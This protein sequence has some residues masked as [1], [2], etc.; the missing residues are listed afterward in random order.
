[1]TQKVD[2]DVEIIRF[3]LTQ[4]L[5]WWQGHLLLFPGQPK[6][7]KRLNCL[8]FREYFCWYSFKFVPKMFK[9]RGGGVNTSTAF[10]TILRKQQQILAWWGFHI[11]YLCI[12]LCAEQSQKSPEVFL[13]LRVLL[14][15]S[16]INENPST[17]K[18]SRAIKY[19]SP[20]TFLVLRRRQKVF[21]IVGA[22]YW[23][24]GPDK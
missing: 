13:V 17:D 18:L 16:R 14:A 21:L 5:N 24:R 2:L 11:K 6:R 9:T 10:R 20:E 23:H 8:D 7:Q 4:S 15:L 22:W 12:L 3:S 1:M 19:I